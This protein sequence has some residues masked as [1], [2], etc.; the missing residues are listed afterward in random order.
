MEVKEPGFVER[1]RQD[2]SNAAYAR[3]D[4]L[5][6]DDLWLEATR[7]LSASRRKRLSSDALALCGCPHNAMSHT[8]WSPAAWEFLAL[9]CD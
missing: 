1:Y 8:R 6:S 4:S 3:C 2:L 9:F 7:G 5:W